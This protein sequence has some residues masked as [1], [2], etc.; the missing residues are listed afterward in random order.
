MKTI[1]LG[2]LAAI[3]LSVTGCQPVSPDA[4]AR[5]QAAMGNMSSLPKVSVT[6]DSITGSWTGTCALDQSNAPMF[7]QDTL[8]INSNFLTLTS[9]FFAN[10]ACTVK[11]FTQSS[12]GSYLLSTDSM[13]NKTTITINVS[14]MTIYPL[15]A[16][17]VTML[18]VKNYCKNSAWILNQFRMINDVTACGLSVTTK[19]DIGRNGANELYFGSAKMLKN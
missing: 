13:Q 15:S 9:T 16:L 18:N 17:S 7:R 14:N 2:I 3:C 4:L 19:T 12:N 10:S 8:D 11:A 5:A 6:N 1:C